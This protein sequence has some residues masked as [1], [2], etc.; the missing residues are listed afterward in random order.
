MANSHATTASHMS[1]LSS[2]SSIL[3]AA[4]FKSVYDRV[5]EIFSR[6]LIDPCLQASLISGFSVSE[7]E[8]SIQKS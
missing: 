8:T 7:A 2:N 6:A 5:I 4:D 3:L 1:K